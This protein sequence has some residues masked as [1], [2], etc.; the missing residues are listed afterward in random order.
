MSYGSNE[1][2]NILLM[3]A[4]GAVG[5]FITDRKWFQTPVTVL[6]ISFVGLVIKEIYNIV[7][8]E[9]RFGFSIITGAL[10]W[11]LIYSLF[12]LIGVLVGD[13]IHGII[14][15]ENSAKKRGIY[16]F[17]TIF[18]VVCL[19]V[20]S[21]GFMGNPLSKHL[22]NVAAKDYVQEKY[23]DMALETSKASYNF[24]TGGYSVEV[25]SK[26]KP[27]THFSLS[28]DWRGK[29]QYDTYVKGET[30]RFNA[31]QR[32]DQEY[33]EWTEK[34]FNKD[35]PFESEISFGTIG[36]D[37]EEKGLEPNIQYDLKEIGKEKGKIVLYVTTDK[38]DKVKM[39]EVLIEVKNIFD[40]KKLN[41]KTIDLTLQEP[42]KDNV[43]GRESLT[44]M[45]FEYKDIKIRDLEEKIQK[46]I[47]KTIAFYEEMDKG[48]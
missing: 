19:G 27:D 3:P 37:S 7:E 13:S 1:F 20:L 42:L 46:N 25:L 48:V 44:I 4:I 43:E 2:Y 33:R 32:V 17:S 36:D 24:K 35:F 23:S 31:W 29:L 39:A 26:N 9:Q 22:S 11:A 38:L 16:V 40:K 8:A 14:N 21:N 6:A 12:A 41:F 34:A 45:D 30:E 10:L 28:F 18:L 47:E 5:Y 15:K